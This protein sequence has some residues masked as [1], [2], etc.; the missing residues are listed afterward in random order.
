M[1]DE[2]QD[3]YQANVYHYCELS[4]ADVMVGRMRNKRFT[5]REIGIIKNHLQHVT[6]TI[7]ETMTSFSS[8]F[9]LVESCV[10]FCKKVLRESSVSIQSVFACV[11]ATEKDREVFGECVGV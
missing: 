11:F 2:E 10:T 6:G 7:L 8:F 1:T 5:D 3:Q 9:V 4:S